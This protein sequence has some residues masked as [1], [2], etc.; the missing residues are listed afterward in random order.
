M[1]PVSSWQRRRLAGCPEA[2]GPP[3]YSAFAVVTA[4]TISNH[5]LQM[6]AESKS[7]KAGTNH[8]MRIGEATPLCRSDAE[9]GT[10]GVGGI[11]KLPL[12]VVGRGNHEYD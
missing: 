5:S 1:I 7:S 2:R 3:S 12:G 8:H 4:S 6:R 10:I 9:R 11:R